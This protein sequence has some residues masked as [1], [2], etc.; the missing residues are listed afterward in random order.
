ML[1]NYCKLFS[2]RVRKDL[3]LTCIILQLLAAA[4]IIETIKEG[5]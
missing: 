2:V 5:T 3:K 4:V 1:K